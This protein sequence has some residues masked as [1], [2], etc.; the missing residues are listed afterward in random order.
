MYELTGKTRLEDY[1]KSEFTAL[2]EVILSAEGGEAYQETLIN[3]FAEIVPNPEGM[4]L[5]FW[6]PDDEAPPSGI[7][8]KIEVYCASEGLMSF[9]I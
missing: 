3:H 8:K 2:I 7:I 6:S 1:T 4:D 9:K 5:I